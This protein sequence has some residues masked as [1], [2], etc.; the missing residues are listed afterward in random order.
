MKL[1]LYCK[2]TMLLRAF[3]CSILCFLFGLFLFTPNLKC[4]SSI[5][6]LPGLAR[7]RSTGGN[8]NNH[9]TIVS[10]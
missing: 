7:F 1:T 9:P 4:S 2:A 6:L 10:V 8:R 5:T 3:A